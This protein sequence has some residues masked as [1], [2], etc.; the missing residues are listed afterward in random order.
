MKKINLL[1][2]KMQRAKDVRRV[3]IITAAVQAAVFLAVLLMYV[4]F[5]LWE[6]RLDREIQDLAH[7]LV[8]SPVQQTANVNLYLFFQDEFLTKDALINAQ[9]VTSGVR[10]SEIRFSLGEFS[11]TAH[12]ADILNIWAHIVLLEGFF[13]DVRLAS[14]AATDDGVY[15][16][17]LNL[18]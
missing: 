15:I 7:A 4:F 18:R 16:Y 8:Q 5:S 11:I 10:L 14:I 17:E 13:Y 6:A 1:P 2:H 3:T 9:K 12:T